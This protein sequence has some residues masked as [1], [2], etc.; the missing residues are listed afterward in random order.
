MT[1][2]RDGVSNKEANPEVYGRSQMFAIGIT[3]AKSGWI[4]WKTMQENGSNEKKKMSWIL[5]QSGLKL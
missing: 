1:S 4:Q 3:T 2:S 5:P